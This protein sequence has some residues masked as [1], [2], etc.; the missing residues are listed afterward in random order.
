MTRNPRTGRYAPQ[1]TRYQCDQ[2][3]LF[4]RVER[5]RRIEARIAELGMRKE[6]A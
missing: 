2:P 4:L 1:G 6:K 3:S 5:A